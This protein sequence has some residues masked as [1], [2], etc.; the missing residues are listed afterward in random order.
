MPKIEEISKH[1]YADVK[2]PKKNKEIIYVLKNA[3]KWDA[4]WE[5]MAEGKIEK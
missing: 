4:H 3:G 5:I 2:F 1:G